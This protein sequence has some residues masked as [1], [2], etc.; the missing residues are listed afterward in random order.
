MTRVVNSYSTAAEG[1]IPNLLYVDLCNEFPLDIWA[2]FT[3][4]GLKRQSPEGVRWMAESITL[5]RKP[6]PTLDYTYSFTSEYE[7][8]Q[9]QDVSMLDFLEL[10]LW[11]ATCSDFYEQAGYHFERLDTKGYD[12]LQLNAERVYRSK[13]DYWKS[14]L[15][16]PGSPTNLC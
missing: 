1:L 16:C 5:L 3:P 4:K 11:M 2:P 12:N 8:W 13:P 6:Y 9:Q 15:T 7:T 14:R 10:H